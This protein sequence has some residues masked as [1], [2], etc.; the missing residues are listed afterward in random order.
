MDHL[1]QRSKEATKKMQEGQRKG[2]S[3]PSNLREQVDEDTMKMFPTPRA[4]EPGRTTKGYGRGLKELI[5]GKEQMWPT[6][7]ANMGARG[8]QPNWT[9]TRPSGQP[10]Q[11]TINQ[12]VRDNPTMWPTPTAGLE[13]HSTK[14]AYW[15]NRIQKG[16]QT[17]IQMEVYKQEQSGSLNPEWVTW[18]QGYPRG[19]TDL[20]DTTDL[21]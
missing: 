7:D 18:L 15:N 21:K 11:Y 14:D 4:Q 16:R 12:A 20:E 13:K 3:R 8:T 17:D 5:E 6:P 10:A 1:P 2:R 19:W 9:K